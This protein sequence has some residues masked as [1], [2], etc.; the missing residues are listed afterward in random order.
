MLYRLTLLNGEEMIF[1]AEGHEAAK[2]EAV[3]MAED[4][5]KGILALECIEPDPDDEE[6][7]YLIV[8][9]L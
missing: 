6:M 4:A 8:R 9:L 3:E 2:A 1:E 5:E 7:Y